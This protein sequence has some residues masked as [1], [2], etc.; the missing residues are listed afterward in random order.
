MSTELSPRLQALQ[1]D[2]AL[3]LQKAV[4]DYGDVVYS[5]SLGIEAIVLMDLIF[6]FAPEIS[7][8]TLDTGRLPPETLDLLDRVE[9]RYKQRIAVF[10]P[11]AESVEKYVH[12]NGINGFY[13]GLAERQGC[14]YVR[15]VEPFMR[16]IQ[17]H[18][19]WVTGVR[20]EQTAERAKS[21]PID[22]DE[23]YSM[24]KVSPILDWTEQD[25]HDYVHAKALPYNVLH[26]QGYPSIG[27][28]PCT[29]AVEPGA[30]PRSGRWWWENPESRECGL[31]PRSKVIP[32]KLEKQSVES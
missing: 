27:C 20:K 8:F 15:K 11:N 4:A 22:W 19:A 1:R 2:S 29:R 31:Q 3:L 25:I 17:G 18:K 12:D 10:Y 24:W 14:C 28:A 30:D 13:A 16:A 7:V 6:S 23:R 26:D 9:R 21:Q 5:T 32:I